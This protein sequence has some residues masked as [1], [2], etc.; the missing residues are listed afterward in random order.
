MKMSEL[1]I[2]K[3]NRDF[4]TIDEFAE[5]L[6]VHYNTV[7]NGIKNGHIQA[8]RIGRGKKSSFRIPHSEISRMALFNLEEVIDTLIEKRKG[9]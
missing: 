6:H 2:V 9:E 4:Y 1:Y 8:F 7:R 5:Y 3:K